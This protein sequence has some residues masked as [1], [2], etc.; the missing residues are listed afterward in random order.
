MNFKESRLEEISIR[1]GNVNKLDADLFPTSVKYLTL[2]EMKIQELSDSF[3]NL[4]NLRR[5][6]L[7][8]NQLK[9]VNPVKL[10]VSTLQT[11]DLKQCN[12]RFISPFWCQCS[13]K[14]IKI[15]NYMYTPRKIQILV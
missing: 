4:E 3:E 9:M 7:A 15:L 6:S 5:L 1:G 13:R 10:P 14:R 2:R 11:L 8:R 12:V